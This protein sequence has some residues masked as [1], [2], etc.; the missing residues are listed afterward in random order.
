MRGGQV[1][2]GT[3]DKSNCIKSVVEK[4]I[5]L[6]CGL[7]IR[8]VLSKISD[9]DYENIKE[10]RIR[11]NRPLMINYSSMDRMLSASGEFVDSVDKSY[12]ADTEDILQ[13]LEL[14]SENSLYAY[15]E[16]LKNGFIT[17]KGGHR[18]GISGKVIIEG[19]GIKVLRD[20][21]GLNI[22]IARQ[23]KGCADKIIKFIINNSSIYHT[24]IISPPNC[25]K[26]TLL[27]DILRQLSNGIESL[28]FMGLKVGLIDERSEIAACYKG[29]P[30]NDIGI[31]TDILDSCPK[32]QGILMLVRSMSPHIIATDE[33]GSQNDIAAVE[34]A[35]NAG[36]KIITTAHAGDTAELSRKSGIGQLFKQGLFE[37]VI[38][39]SNS[40][41]IG[42]IEDIIN[43]TTLTSIWRCIN[44]S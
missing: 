36:I 35:L 7:R 13:T 10:I 40:R 1:V 20:I 42:T 28:G 4:D 24:L 27:R 16:E 8:G 29:A 6:C 5:L 2:M 33:L 18:V 43:G 9:M 23:V 14:M 39:L 21:S 11:L 38:I 22:R 32:A 44:V 31:R 19:S 26:T 3:N 12:I 34:E 25:G 30:Q 15:Q 37:R 17:L 41:G